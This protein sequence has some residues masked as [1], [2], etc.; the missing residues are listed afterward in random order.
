MFIYFF[1]QSEKILEILHCFYFVLLLNFNQTFLQI[2]GFNVEV[3]SRYVK[4]LYQNVKNDM[5]KCHMSD[6]S[7]FVFYMHKVKFY[8]AAKPLEILI[9]ALVKCIFYFKIE[10]LI[11]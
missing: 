1:A 4:I 8:N 2:L 3:V 6:M 9:H 11:S 5:S 10:I 7:K